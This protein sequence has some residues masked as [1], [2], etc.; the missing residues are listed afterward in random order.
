MAGTPHDTPED[1]HQDLVALIK[2][3]RD[4]P[5]DMDQALA[6]SYM[7]KHKSAGQSGQ[8]PTAQQAV[9][10]QDASQYPQVFGRFTPVVGIVFVAA[11]Y[12]AALALGGHWLWWLIFPLM[13]MAFGGWRGYGHYHDERYRL[14]EERRMA[15]D[16]W[17]HGRYMARMGYP[18]REPEQLPERSSTRTPP[19]QQPAPPATPPSSSPSS[20]GTE[21]PPANPAG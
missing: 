15:R 4:L 8:N 16:Q 9:V 10:P 5:P 13:G 7:E 21:T 3:G 1:A 20:S 11:I 14:H 17:R 6:E 12:V 18:P 2:A 19:T